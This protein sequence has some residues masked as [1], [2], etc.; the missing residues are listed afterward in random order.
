MHPQVI[1]IQEILKSLLL[2][3]KDERYVADPSSFSHDLAMDVNELTNLDIGWHL[4]FAIA[5]SKKKGS[6]WTQY[7]WEWSCRAKTIRAPNYKYMRW[8]QLLAQVEWQRCLIFLSVLM[9]YRQVYL[10]SQQNSLLDQS[11]T[12]ILEKPSFQKQM[13]QNTFKFLFIYR[14]VYGHKSCLR[15]NYRKSDLFYAHCKPF[16]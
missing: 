2:E 3:M 15:V 5:I 13:K 11:N 14:N 10:S 12:T 6:C 9:R 16:W 4:I 1:K 8:T 7:I